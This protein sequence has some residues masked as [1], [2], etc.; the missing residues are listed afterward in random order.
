MS[1]NGLTGV[2]GARLPTPQDQAIPVG[3]VVW[4]AA[5]DLSDRSGRRV[6]S[7]KPDQVLA[8]LVR[9]VRPYATARYNRYD[10]T[11][12]TMTSTDSAEFSA[13]HSKV[14]GYLPVSAQDGRALLL[15]GLGIETM[16]K[17]RKD[18][19]GFYRDPAMAATSI[20]SDAQEV[21]LLGLT[22]ARE[23][24]GDLGDLETYANDSRQFINRAKNV[25][26]LAQ[27]QLRQQSEA[28]HEIAALLPKAT[29]ADETASPSTWHAL[30]VGSLSEAECRK[31]L[32]QAVSVAAAATA[33]P[34][35]DEDDDEALRP[36]MR[37]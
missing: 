6:A 28:L 11:P 24:G 26:S 20:L 3:S 21:L 30:Q 8:L 7:V 34:Q 36:R 19:T 1:E 32:L 14:Q 25:L 15:Y 5:K 31:L 27:E 37:G 16:D 35:T 12:L 10:L 4:V 18:V 13:E 33:K 22:S 9:L 29:A 17:L 23:R 2:K